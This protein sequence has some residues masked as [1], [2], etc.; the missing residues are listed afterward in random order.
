MSSRSFSF[1]SPAWLQLNLVINYWKSKRKAKKEGFIIPQLTDYFPAVTVQLPLFNEKYVVKRLL[2]AVSKLDY[3]KEQMQIQVLDD[4]TDET[5][6]LVADET[7][8]LKEQGF[9]IEHI[10][11]SN[12]E[13]YK[14]GALAFGLKSASGEFYCHFRFRFPAATRFPEKDPALFRR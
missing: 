13:G 4:S 11:R 9:N 5:V 14:A 12:R 3:P 7:N 10:Q 6:E 2:D 1:L 8:K